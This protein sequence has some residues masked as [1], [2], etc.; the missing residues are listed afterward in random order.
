MLFQCD[1]TFTI[2]SK[3]YQAGVLSLQ[4]DYTEDMEDRKCNLMVIYGTNPGDVAHVEFI[5][6]SN[7]TPLLY[8]SKVEEYQNLKFFFNILSY[9]TLAIFVISLPHKM[10]GV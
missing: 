3:S 1:S 8:S 6:D 9:L 2:T 5:V 10:V 4:I 7:N